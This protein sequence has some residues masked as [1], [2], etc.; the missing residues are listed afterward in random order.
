[1]QASTALR[2]HYMHNHIHETIY[3]TIITT[4]NISYQIQSYQEQKD[5]FLRGD[6]MYLVNIKWYL[7]QGRKKE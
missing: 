6:H 1:M 2:R 7:K 3:Q 4:K 5:Q